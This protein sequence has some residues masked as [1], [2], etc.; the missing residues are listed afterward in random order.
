[1][2]KLRNALTAA[3]FFATL[4]PGISSEMASADTNRQG[5]TVPAVVSVAY[6]DPRVATSARDV[7]RQGG[8]AVAGATRW[9]AS[10][11]QGAPVGAF[12]APGVISVAY[13]DPRI[14]TGA[15]GVLRQGGLATAGAVRWVGGPS[16]AAEAKVGAVRLGSL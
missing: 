4:A 10:S 11:D 16:I 12:A 13:A 15:A 7:G 2:P 14:A 6:R 3:F 9:M 5:L 8:F 1:M